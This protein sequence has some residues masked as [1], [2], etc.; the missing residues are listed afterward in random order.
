MS[1]VR[2]RFAP[3]PTGRAGASLHMGVARTAI[4]NWLLAR[5]MR[6]AFVLRV[7]DTDAER[8]NPES[9]RSILESLRWLG[10]DW[11]EGPDVGGPHGPYRQSERLALY[12]EAADRLVAEG[13]AYPCFCSEER[14]AARREAAK[15]SGED[16]QYDGGCGNLRP[17][18]AAARAESEPHTIRFRMPRRDIV[19]E[20]VV[21]GS[22]NFPA[23][24]V[25]DFVLLR[26]G[27]LPVYNFACVVDDA[28]MEISHVLRG[29][30]H[31]PNT[32]RQLV[33]YE[34]LGAPV[35]VFAHLSMILGEDRSKLSKRH[36]AVAVESY[37]EKGY[38]PAAFVNYLALLGWSPGDDREVMGLDE[39]IEA[40]S[41]ERLVK[42]GAVFDAAK[43]D[44]FAGLK[45]REEGAAALLPAARE[46]LP[47]DDDARR[48]EKLSVVID[49]IVCAAD[50]PE[51]LA[52]FADEAPVPDA[53][54]R[55]WLDRAALFGAL[56]EAISSIDGEL[57]GQD[58]KAAVKAAGQAAGA[59]GK[60]LFMPLRAALTGRTH[61]PDLA[62]VA[63]VLGRE[64]VLERLR[65]RAT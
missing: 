4:F 36:G 13:K 61:G 53:E 27:G 14:L 43:L 25:G 6:G 62:A 54:A 50:L 12:R 60:E 39:L 64:R 34:A 7:E 47:E 58:F 56:A 48:L 33:L 21:R 19:V 30:D 32:I 49:R 15:A 5:K 45:I 11:D 28:A 8:S 2:V 37:R 22:V 51:Q 26:D 55:E 10:L 31:L 23:G 3:S 63:A 65:A 40:F 42:S 29:E 46:L 35:P 24:M 38:P 20:D 9:E 52:V 59:K 41:L 57:T 16:P 1:K 44:W 17:E 18:E